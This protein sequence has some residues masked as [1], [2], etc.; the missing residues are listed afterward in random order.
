MTDELLNVSD[1]NQFVYCPR[2]YWYLRFFDTQGRNYERTEGQSMHESQSTRG[3]WLNELYLEDED[4]G[5][6]GK[7]DVLE[8]NGEPIPIERKR[9]E[10]GD[11]YKSDELQLAGYCL[12]LE[13][14]LG[15]PVREG[16]IYLYETD[17][18]MHVRITDKLREAVRERIA[19]MRAMDPD[20]VP[21]ITENPKKCEGCST[22]SYCLPRE[23][24]M[25][26]PDRIPSKEWEA[27]V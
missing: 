26:E 24:L 1:L 16:A 14:H 6:K 3:G 23:T 25:L 7:I 22:R 4:L 18:R 11:Y 13:A 17:Q 15:E 10:S 9:A 2:R 27:E 12:L 5:L 8:L 20:D 19:A 21:P